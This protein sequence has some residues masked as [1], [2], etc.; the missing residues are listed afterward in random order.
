MERPPF[1]VLSWFE[2]VAFRAMRW[3]NGNPLWYLWQRY[4]IV[5]FVGAIVSRRIVYRG[6]E[7]VQK[8]P[9]DAA[10]LLVANHRTFFDQ[11]VLGWILWK[12]AGFTQ[13]LN[14]PVRATFFYENPLGLAI[15]MLMSGGTMFPP[16][17]RKAERKAFNKYALAILLEKLRTPG[18]MVGFHPEGKR[19]KSDNPYELLPAQPGAGELA[20]KARPTVVPAFITG[21]SNSLWREIRGQTQV[22]AVF[23]EPIALPQVEGETRL[24]HHKR[25]A[26]LLNERIAAL[27]EE[28]KRLRA[29]GTEKERERSGR[30]T[31]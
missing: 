23:G 30:G 18:Q 4:C 12:R 11:F 8:L 26:D 24:A 19:N 28:E 29:Q 10:I 21:L 7:R 13:R 17:F 22:V 6:L 27:F 20:L 9:P 3:A 1:E 2:R 25:T 15:C 31:G 5:P 14:F 16:F